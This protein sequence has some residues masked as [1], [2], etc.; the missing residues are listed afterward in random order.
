[1]I[2]LSEQGS[3]DAKMITHILHQMKHQND[4]GGW[5]ELDSPDYALDATI[6]GVL[7]P[8]AGG[9]GPYDIEPL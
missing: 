1:V 7:E 5:L 3:Y 8:L 2:D 6:V 4:T 9:G